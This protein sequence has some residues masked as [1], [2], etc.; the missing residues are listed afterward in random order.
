MVTSKAVVHVADLAADQAYVERN[1]QTVAA[2]ELGGVRTI[3][4]VPMLK[5][6]ELVG[7]FSL[8][9]QEVRPFTEKQI[10]LL[11]N[12]AAQAVIAIENAR[13]LNELRQRT[14]D[15]TELLEQQTAT[16][17]VLRV[18]SSS[19]GELDPVF[20]T[21]LHNAARIC[22]ASFG[23]LAF[24]ENDLWRTV[25]VTE[26]SME[27]KWAQWLLAEPR[28]FGPETALGRL[29]RSK[30]LVHISD[31]GKDVADPRTSPTRAAFLETGAQALLA[32][33]LLKEGAIIGVVA[34]YRRECRPFTDKQIALVTSFASQAVI[35]IENTRLLNELRWRT[36]DLTELLEQQTATAE[37]LGVISRSKFELQ[38]ILQSVVET[39]MRLCRAEQA[40]IYR[41]EDGVY[42]FAAGYSSVPEYLKIE[43]QTEIVPGP[44]SV[45]GRAVLTRQVARIDDAWT[46]PQYENKE[47]AKVGGVRSMIGVPLMREGEAIGVI[48][49]ARNRVEPF[50]VREIELVA[51]FAD[52][53]VIAIENVRLFEA[54][55]QRTRELTELLQQQTATADV[56]KVISR[57]T[58]DL[59]AVLD[60]LVELAARLCE[61]EMAAMSRQ[62]GETYRQIASYGYSPELNEFMA[63]NPI[64]SGRASISGRVMREGRAV[65]IADVQTDPEYEFKEGAKIGGIRTMLGV[66]LLREGSPIGMFAL[67]RTSVRP[68]TNKQIELVETFADQAAI[69]IENV[70]LFEAEQ[71]RTYELTELLEQQT[72]TS[73]VLQVI[74]SSPGD[75]QRV[76]DAILNNA[77]RIC[78]AENATLF[79]HKDGSLRRA[80]RFKDAGDASIPVQP[81]ARSGT[82]RMLSTKQIVHIRDY[83]TEPA[84]LEGDPFVVATVDRFGIRTLLAVPM[85]KEGELVGGIA[86]WR[87]EGRPFSD[88]QI[89]LITSF[90][91][92]AVIAIENARLLNELRQ[93]TDDLSELLE[94]QT[95]TSNVLEVISRSAFDL[96]AVFE[97]VAESSTRLC[98]ADRAFIFRFDGE[99]LRV[100]A[101]CNASREMKEFV[102]RNP[103]RPG[104]QSASA[105]A[106]LERRTIHIP[107]VLADPEYSYAMSVRGVEAFRTLLAVPI[108]KGDDLLGVVMI[109]HVEEV[110]PFTE[111]H[112]ALVETFADQA[113]IAI[114]NVRLFEAEQQRT[115]ELTESLEQQTATSEVLQVISSS[116]GELRPVFET[117]LA[118]ATRICEAGFGM[119]WLAEGEGFRS[120]ALHGVPPEF[121]RLRQGFLVP[122]LIPT[123]RSTASSRPDS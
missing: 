15:L 66:P 82:G 98:G 12:F 55:Q 108:L 18:I 43:R 53:A 28:S 107:D 65:Q 119:L 33:P 114:E 91:N 70:R 74:S 80:A 97:T 16:S 58:F 72:A 110:R 47:D 6:G 113:A 92:Q 45:V 103:I 35:A 37:V 86:I 27:T 93:R 46:D 42:R 85:L 19:P 48:G 29:V 115:R 59:Q 14:T 87:I 118:S 11:Q 90:A 99:L 88:K 68:F 84:Y 106:A 63:R 62:S 7:A 2:V 94:Q 26:L 105:R 40:V 54:E 9:R 8:Y 104:R 32:A 44:G 13:L 50:V 17:E 4:A 75:L 100:V 89:E 116:P 69:A 21:I 41:L 121:A 95:A 60:T 20:Q 120:V 34:F 1:P 25:A 38:P 36:D 31:L 102:E 81:G 49:L 24:Y 5:D 83:L 109:Y 10:E 101:D 39:A 117:M 77:V 96:H 112:I 51:T 111:K 3:L 122:H 78:R 76:F 79:L 56:L 73:D 123:F 57:S 64:P 22:D 71:Q 30:Q 52:Q 23:M 61:A 67:S